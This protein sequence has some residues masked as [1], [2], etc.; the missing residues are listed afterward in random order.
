MNGHNDFLLSTAEEV[1]YH[2]FRY[3]IKKGLEAL[4]VFCTSFSSFIKDNKEIEEDVVQEV[5]ELLQII[6]LAVEKKD[7]LIAA[8]LLK[9][10]L[11]ERIK[12]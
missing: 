1:A 7:F 4:S 11:L 12:R 2:F 5:N 8:D 10:E 9:F 3:E 6:L